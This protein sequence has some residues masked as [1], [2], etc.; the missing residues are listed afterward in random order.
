MPLTFGNNLLNNI[1]LA[2]ASKPGQCSLHPTNFVNLF[3][4]KYGNCSFPK[5]SVLKS[6][7]TSSL[8][9]L[10]LCCFTL[11]SYT[12]VTPPGPPQDTSLRIIQIIQGQRLREK[13]LDSATSIQTIA[14]KVILQ[15]GLTIFY[16]DS[17]VINKSTNVLE[18]YG[19]IHIN[20]NDSIHTYSQTLRYIGNDR[21]AYLRKDVRLTD[22]KGTLYTQDLEYDLKTS[23]GKYRNGGKVVNG[24]TV[25]T[26][27]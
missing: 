18:A 26:S 6:A 14:G 20:Q 24:K 1:L 4:N 25:L 7:F 23:I 15:E 11:V 8:I 9:L 16:C 21:I 10:F 27:T 2:L 12:Q 19:N 17:A 22:N 13:T 5:P 3:V